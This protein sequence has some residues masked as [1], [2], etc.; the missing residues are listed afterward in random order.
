MRPMPC[1][2]DATS[3]W[4]G[5]TSVTLRSA[6]SVA[7]FRRVAGWCHMRGCIA[8]AASTGARVQRAIAATRSSALPCARRARKSAVAG[9]MATR[10]AR[11]AMRT[12]SS[13]GAAGSHMSIATGSPVMPASVTG[14]RNRAADAVIT[15][16][17]LAPALTSKRATA[18]ALY[19]AML[20]VTHSATVRPARRSRTSVLTV[21]APYPSC[22]GARRFSR[23]PDG[24]R[25][26]G[27]RSVLR[28]VRR[29]I[30]CL[31]SP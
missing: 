23:F 7:T 18:A 27:R 24:L 19:A 11:S 2:P 22:S 10:S 9:T 30:E 16:S 28:T 3:P 26:S 29:A 15:G 20:P 25:S 5:P 31:A 12:W 17:T 8:G 6:A 4:T 1:S 14:P 13:P 21:A